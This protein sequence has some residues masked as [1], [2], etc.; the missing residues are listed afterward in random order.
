MLSD[1][2]EILVD[3]ELTPSFKVN[4][5]NGMEWFKMV[6][7]TYLLV[8]LY[9]V[10]TGLAGFM[11]WKEEGFRL[12]TAIF[13]FVSIGIL[14]ILFLSN[15]DTMFSLLIVAFILLHVL[16]IIEGLIKFGRLNYRHHII[17]FIFHCGIILMV[18]VF[19]K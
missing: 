12:L 7:I 9:V 19:I 6:F 17:R 2:M 18:Y 10:L 8:G 16:A 15:K 1:L 5:I 11:Q 14:S 3:M 13:I 4:L